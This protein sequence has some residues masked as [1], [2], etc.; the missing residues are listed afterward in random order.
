MRVT[1]KWPSMSTQISAVL[2]SETVRY[3]GRV[4][5]AYLGMA[6]L[7]VELYDINQDIYVVIT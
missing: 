7:L 6:E 5:S 4:I 1:E 3:V 2:L